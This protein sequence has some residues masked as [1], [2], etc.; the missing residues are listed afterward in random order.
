MGSSASWEIGVNLS[1][2]R[3][4]L[5]MRGLSVKSRIPQTCFPFGR[6]K[7]NLCCQKD[8]NTDPRTMTATKAMITLTMTV[9]TMSK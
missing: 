4:L 7:P 8:P 6:G 3:G 5:A 1:G 2:K 9:M